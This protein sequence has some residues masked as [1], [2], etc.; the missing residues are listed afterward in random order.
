MP[1]LERT[2]LSTS[3]LLDFC[4]EKEL[5]AQTGHAIDDWPLVVVKELVDNGLDACEEANVAPEISVRADGTGI[6]VIDNGPG[7]PGDT[8]N[9][10][11]DFSVRV[12]SREAYVAPD[13]GAQGN[14]L[15]TIVAMPYVLD[16]HR[17]RV[18]ISAG[19]V[20]HNIDFTVDPIRQEPKVEIGQYQS[21]VKTGSAIT[22]E[23]P[24][25]ACSILADAKGRFLQIADDYAWI[26]PH[27]TLT[28]DWFGERRRTEA[29]D[30]AWPS[31]RPSDPTSAHWYTEQHLERLIAGYVA[32]DQDRGETRTV[33]AFVSEFRGLSGSAKQKVVLD[34]TGLARANLTD[35][36]NSAGV[37]GDIVSRLLK[38]MQANS[39]PVK[40]KQLGV[41][42]KDHFRCRF[43]AVGCEMESFNYRKV[44]DTT[45]GVPW[46]VETAFGWCPELKTRRLVT[47]V[48]WSPG[49][50]NP[51]RQLGRFGE[52]L[53]S[54]LAE[55]R[56]SQNEPII[57]VLHMSCPRVEYTDRGKSSV[58]VRS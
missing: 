26:N 13:R 44:E 46:I 14:A 35:L 16:G 42:G 50:V 40:P 37:D 34:A 55:K 45:D 10:V 41:I 15:K 58:V 8:I 1:D 57:L 47:G 23:W 7:I 25:L 32:H 6:T 48:N 52:S 27:L 5:I 54:V 18:D 56:A 20:R 51:F 9:G 39:K 38:A 2:T 31:W 12:S 22:V 4:S 19:G 17:G 11:L 24:D 21:D 28:L 36:C 29:T 43:E 53:D 49:I 3:R 33:R 30:T